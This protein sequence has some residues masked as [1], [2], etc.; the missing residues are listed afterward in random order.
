M[1][2]KIKN[3]DT[4]RRWDTVLASKYSMA[5][6]IVALFAAAAAI[7]L[8]SV[9]LLS[10]GRSQPDAPTGLS[11]KLL[12]GDISVRASSFP[13]AGD[14]DSVDA[15]LIDIQAIAA[16]ISDEDVRALSEDIFEKSKFSLFGSHN[17]GSA[18]SFSTRK[19]RSKSDDR[20]FFVQFSTPADIYTLAALGKFSGRHVVSHVHDNLFVAIGNQDFA[21]KARRF[22]GVVWV[23]ERAGA[24]KLGGSL[25]LYLERLADD[26]FISKI[27]RH[28]IPSTRVSDSNPVVTLVAQCW[29]DACGIASAEVKHLCS[30]VYVH[31]GAVEVVCAADMVTR[32]ASLLSSKVGI[33]HIEI[34]QVMETQNFAGSAIVGTGPLAANPAQSRVL[35]Q[36]SVTNSVI[37]VADSGININNCFFHPMGRVVAAYRFFDCTHCGRCN[38]QPPSAA[39]ACGNNI[40]ES[41]HGTHVCGTVA[42]HAAAN[43]AVSAGNG[44]ASGARIFFQDTENG[45]GSLRVPTTLR[46][47]FQEAYDFGACVTPFSV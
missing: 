44:V 30:D 4:Q 36:I 46:N 19:L 41:A 40:D 20:Q 1:A 3:E 23:Q 24:D 43:P 31:P 10:L 47:M 37:A 45:L 27:R 5:R 16:S 34:K 2:F 29:Y 32:A 35:S 26:T 17:N 25:K 33:E 13:S 28:Y 6:A 14:I 15:D 42:G 22:P 11:I 38:G 9:F 7:V 8:C 39:N 21:S 12:H 18:A